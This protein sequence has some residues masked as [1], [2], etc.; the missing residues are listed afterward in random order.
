MFAAG[1]DWIS[2]QRWGRWRSFISHEYIWHD[3][4][5]FLHF[6]ERIAS[7]FVLN[8]YLV[9]VAPQHTPGPIQIL[10]D[11]HMGRSYTGCSRLDLRQEE[12][13]APL[14][15]HP[16]GCMPRATISQSLSGGNCILV[17]FL[18]LVD[19]KTFG[20]S[21]TLMEPLRFI[22]G[23]P[24]LIFFRPSLGCCSDWKNLRNV[25]F[26]R[27]CPFFLYASAPLFNLHLTS[28]FPFQPAL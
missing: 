6:G 24:P 1:L 25:R 26:N 4:D 28:A 16:L 18:S 13:L 20:R 12:N 22:S 9:E 14:L 3:A 27:V 8:K 11:F 10:P 2:I 15:N 23:A 19:L 17:R 7:T 21:R 5:R